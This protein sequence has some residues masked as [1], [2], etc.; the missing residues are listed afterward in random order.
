[1]KMTKTLTGITIATAAALAFTLAPV[2]GAQAASSTGTVK[3]VG[4][5]SCKGKGACKTNAKAL[6][7]AKAKAL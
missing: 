1:M 5:N 3:C 2:I 4:A 6:I 7:L